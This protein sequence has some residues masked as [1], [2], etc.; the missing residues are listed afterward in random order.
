MGSRFRNHPLGLQQRLCGLTVLSVMLSTSKMISLI[1]MSRPERGRCISRSVA[2]PQY[3]GLSWACH[4][5]R[6]PH[7]GMTSLGTTDGLLW[8]KCGMS[9]TGSSCIKHLIPHW[10][11]WLGLWRSAGRHRSLGEFLCPNSPRWEKAMLQGHTARDWVL[12]DKHSLVLSHR[13]LTGNP[14]SCKTLSGI[15]SQ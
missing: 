11:C 8:F 9:P 4:W 15:R 13:F 7:A 3:P 14:S 2:E 12:P 1:S 5:N 10:R 6:L